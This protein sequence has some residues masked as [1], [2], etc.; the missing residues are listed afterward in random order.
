MEPTLPPVIVLAGGAS[1]RMG[2]DKRTVPIDG[3]PMFQRT[4][5]RLGPGPVI[6]VVD[7]RAPMPI[8]LAGLVEIVPDTRPGEGPL[9]ALEAGLLATAAPMVAVVAGD[10]PWLAPAVL[11]LLVTRL[12]EKQTV[13]VACIA[14]EDSPIPLPLAVRR[15]VTLPLVSALLDHGERR[16]RALLVDALVIPSADWLP[17]D[18]DQGTLRDVDTPADLASVR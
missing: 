14:D 4:L 6:V 3:V 12:A 16:L 13:A 17:L 10:M 5:D 11:D 8:P 7:P 1:R 9:A 18:P 15:D 2:I